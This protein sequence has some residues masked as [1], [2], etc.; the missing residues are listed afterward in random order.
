[1][2]IMIVP[3]RDV[4]RNKLMFA[5]SIDPALAYGKCY[6]HIS[7]LVQENLLLVTVS[8]IMTFVTLEKYIMTLDFSQI[9]MFISIMM[10][11]FYSYYV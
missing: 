5:T 8:K 6:K 3:P 2:K 7:L 10:H 9:N 4:V 1:M 11:L